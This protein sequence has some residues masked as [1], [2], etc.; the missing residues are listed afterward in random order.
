MAG[1]RNY[2]AEIQDRRIRVATPN[3]ILLLFARLESLVRE[4]DNAAALSDELVRYF[5]V[6]MVACIE[7]YTR[8]MIQDLVDWGEPFSDRIDK[9]ENVRLEMATMKAI[10]GRRITLGELIAHLLPVSNLD[11]VKRALGILLDS[12]VIELVKESLAK[13]P[14]DCEHRSI[15]IGELIQGVEWSFRLRH[16]YAHEFPAASSIN[17]ELIDESVRFAALFLRRMDEAIRAQRFPDRGS[18]P[19]ELERYSAEELKARTDDLD[20]WVATIN[21]NLDDEDAGR[22]NVAQS[23]WRVVRD[24][25]AQLMADFEARGLPNWRTVYNLAAIELTEHRAEEIRVVSS[26]GF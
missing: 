2:V 19:D 20:E 9:F 18:T 16:M 12:D 3:Q 13:S 5:P 7:T 10:H 11:D 1:K 23:A 6:G 14:A 4:L 8:L 25:T 22:L 17:R 24:N 21:A 15:G 26:L